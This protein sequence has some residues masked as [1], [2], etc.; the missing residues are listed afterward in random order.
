MVFSKRIL[1]LFVAGVSCVFSN[2]EQACSD[3]VFEIDG[4][5]D[6]GLDEYNLNTDFKWSCNAHDRCYRKIGKSKFSC[7]KAFLKNLNDSCD[8]LGVWDVLFPVTIPRRVIQCRSTA[9]TYYE[10]VRNAPSAK[11]A[12]IKDQKAAFRTALKLTDEYFSSNCV[13]NETPSSLFDS[14]ESVV[15]ERLYMGYL[16]RKPT[17]SELYAAHQYQNNSDISGLWEY[18]VISDIQGE[19]RLMAAMLIA[20][21]HV[22]LR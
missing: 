8:E 1:V 18:Y 9:K 14:N 21:N 15:T 19:N 6:M 3:Y 5:S 10:A 7:D 2:A 12:Y 11:N 16:N 22:L 20:V 4:C 17:E 13:A